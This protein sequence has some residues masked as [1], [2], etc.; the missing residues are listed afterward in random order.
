MMMCSSQPSD[1]PTAW[2]GSSETAKETS[3]TSSMK[4]GEA[5]SLSSG[6]Y[7]STRGLRYRPARD[8]LQ[9]KPR[10]KRQSVHD[11]RIRWTNRDSQ[12]IQK[13]LRPVGR[14]RA[15]RGPRF[16]S[17][18]EARP[19]QRLRRIRSPGQDRQLA[20][21]I[22]FRLPPYRRCRLGR[23]SLS[24]DLQRQ[25]LRAPN[26][27]RS[28]TA[29]DPSDLRSAGVRRVIVRPA[30]TRLPP[31]SNTRPIQPQ[32]HRQRR[33]P[34]LRQRR[35]QQPPRNRSRILHTPPE[36]RTP[37]TTTRSRRSKPGK[38]LHQ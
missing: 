5:W 29:T 11:N 19:T 14:T 20:N 8:H 6:S 1:P 13:R 23:L 16:P 18:R 10:W 4:E 21:V 34:L 3:Y 33:G 28:P 2:T 7:P 32:Q 36:R 37:R 38:R 12:T 35:L 27:P 31:S 15:L 17:A 26:R 24:L 9:N 30:K 25:R 22:C